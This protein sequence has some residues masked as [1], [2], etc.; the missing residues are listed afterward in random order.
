MRTFLVIEPYPVPNLPTR[1]L[2]CLEPLPMDTLFLDCRNDP[3][4]QP[5]L[6][7]V[8]SST[9][10]SISEGK[11]SKAREASEIVVLP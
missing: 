10:S 1:M 11:M 6:L 5:V 4:R 2:Q 9:H 3:L 8:A 7:R